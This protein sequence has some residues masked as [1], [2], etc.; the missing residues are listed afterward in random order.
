MSDSASAQK[1]SKYPELFSEVKLS[2]SVIIFAAG[3]PVAGEDGAG[4]ER[5]RE[6]QKIRPPL[7]RQ[8][9]FLFTDSSQVASL[10]RVDSRTAKTN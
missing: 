9:Q 10:P 2:V 4:E 1:S 7:K 3:T 8:A 6:T 5:W